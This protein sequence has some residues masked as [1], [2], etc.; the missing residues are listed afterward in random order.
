MDNSLLEFVIELKFGILKWYWP[1]EN[2]QFADCNEEPSEAETQ[3]TKWHGCTTLC[4]TK[5]SRSCSTG[6][7]EMTRRSLYFTTIPNHIHSTMVNHMIY[8]V[9]CSCHDSHTK[10]EKVVCL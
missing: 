4:R 10:N 8:V 3:F 2:W 5:T 1:S 6:C 9:S 7:R